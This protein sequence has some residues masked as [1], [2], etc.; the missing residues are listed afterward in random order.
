VRTR[1]DTPGLPSS[2]RPSTVSRST[3]GVACLLAVSAQAWWA[4]GAAGGPAGRVDGEQDPGG[5]DQRGGD[6]G[7][8]DGPPAAPGSDRDL[9]GLMPGTGRV[10]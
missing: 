9:N 4:G 6:G 7:A 2:P 8:A 5:R 10:R 1:Y 3:S